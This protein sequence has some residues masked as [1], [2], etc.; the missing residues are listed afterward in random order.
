MKMYK[1][2]FLWWHLCTYNLLT[3]DWI[4]REYLRR[5][6]TNKIDFFHFVFQKLLWPFQR[7]FSEIKIF[8]SHK[9]IKPTL[10]FRNISHNFYP[11]D[12]FHIST[13]AS[14]GCSNYLLIQREKD[15]TFLLLLTWSLLL[16]YLSTLALF[17]HLSLDPSSKS[18]II[19]KALWSF[20][21]FF[22]H[23]WKRIKS[24]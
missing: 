22:W 15:V 14:S 3:W 18:S 19:R 16:P 23:I 2:A 12:I 13:V 1:K 5:Q 4:V 8:K 20:L 6:E 11:I 10:P 24:N 9:L 21:G 17:I 7:L